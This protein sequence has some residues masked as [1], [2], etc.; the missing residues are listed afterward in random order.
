M[1]EP[2]WVHHAIWWHVYPLGSTGAYPASPPPGPEEHRLR[3]LVGWLDHVQRLGTNGVLLGPVFAS[4]THGYDT[5]DH[6]RVDPRLGD[7]DDLDLLVA[8]AHDRGLRVVLDGVFHHVGSEHPW[9]RSGS[10]W[11][12][13]DRRGDLA[14]FEGHPGLIALDHARPE[15]RDHVVEVMA[16]WLGRGVDGW[17]LDAAYAVPAEFW[18]EVLPRVRERFGEAWF[19][20]EVIHGDQ[21]AIARATT[22]D[23]LTQYE[24]WKAVWSSLND[25]NPHELAHALRRHDGFTDAE[26]PATFVGNHDVTRLASRLD[27]RRTLPLALAVLFTVAGTPT[28]YAGDEFGLTGIK[29]DREGGDDAVRPELPADPAELPDG[30][31]L[32]VLHLHRELIGVR[33]RHDWLHAARLEVVHVDHERITWRSHHEGRALLVT[34]DYGDGSRPPNWWFEE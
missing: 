24:L 17:R 11:L 18:A 8:E 23:S 29:E 15:V 5:V 12:R 25:R 27:D 22:I 7:S 21:A 31:D 20:G 6:L 30:A 3:R 32:D 16:H 13:R 28:V 2:A 26:V 19:L 34:L 9:V 4:S 14:T 33:R 10:A 1:S